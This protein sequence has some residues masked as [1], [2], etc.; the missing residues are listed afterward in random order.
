MNRL[1]LVG[2]RSPAVR[3]HVRIPHHLDALRQRDRI[4]LDAYWIPTEDITSADALDGFDGIWLLPGSPYRNEDGAITAVRAARERGIPFLGTCAGFQHA[5]IE[6]ARNVCGLTG[7]QHGE[8]APDGDDLLI[9]PLA[10]S[11]VGHEAA[12]L[13]EPGSLAERL[14]G[15][16]RTIERYLCAYGLDPRYLDVLRAGGVHFTGYGEEGEPRIAELPDHPFF[17]ATLFQPE[18]APDLHPLIRAFATAVTTSSSPT[19]TAPAALPT[20]APAASLAAIPATLPATLPAAL[21]AAVPATL[22]A[23][24]PADQGQRV[25][26]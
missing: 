25:V 19:T 26:L 8:T 12:V 2:D 4:D 1:A 17:L 7:A 13:I 3:S 14:L 16:N 24:V 6:Y 10:C 15:T 22:P 23:A 11:L 20:A 9:V 21:P 5:L 18:L